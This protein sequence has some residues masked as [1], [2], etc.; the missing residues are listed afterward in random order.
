[1][2]GIDFVITENQFWEVWIRVD[3]TELRLQNVVNEK[4]HFKI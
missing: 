3:L 1:M 4:I 2:F